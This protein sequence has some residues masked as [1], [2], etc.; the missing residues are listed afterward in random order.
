MILFGSQLMSV[1][2]PFSSTAWEM[3]PFWGDFV[4]VLV[5]KGR[6]IA[7]LFSV[8]I[9][10]ARWLMITCSTLGKEPRAAGEH[11]KAFYYVGIDVAGAHLDAYAS[12][13]SRTTTPGRR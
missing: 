10:V 13:T 6:G 3:G 9:I 2:T 7:C 8:G 1:R 12:G 5:N 11:T 4:S